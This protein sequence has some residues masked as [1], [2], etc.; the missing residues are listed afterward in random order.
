MRESLTDAEAELS[1]VA[2]ETTI[3]A[4]SE[5]RA[6]ALSALLTSQ[7]STLSECCQEASVYCEETSAVTA[8]LRDIGDRLAEVHRPRLSGATLDCSTKRRN[9]SCDS[10]GSSPTMDASAV[11]D[12]KPTEQSEKDRRLSEVTEEQD[13]KENPE[14][15]DVSSQNARTETSVVE[16]VE[17]MFFPAET[18]PQS[19][20]LGNELPVKGKKTVKAEKQGERRTPKGRG[21]AMW[22]LA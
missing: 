4:D 6:Q 8:A 12:A 9:P 2:P 17:E 19:L 3:Y 16:A 13:E 21:Q 10:V 1:A 22:R 5:D 11:A 18:Q 7:N 15:A 14:A 20:T